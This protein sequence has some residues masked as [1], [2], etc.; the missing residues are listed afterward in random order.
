MLAGVNHVLKD[1][2]PGDAAANQASYG[3]PSLPISPA[4]VEAITEFVLRDRD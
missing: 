3:D 1:V 2:P 4:V